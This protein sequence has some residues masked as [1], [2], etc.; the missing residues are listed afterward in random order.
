[1]FAVASIASTPTSLTLPPS[2]L[3]TTAPT[4]QV[5]TRQTAAALAAPLNNLPLGNDAK[6]STPVTLIAN[7]NTSAT[8]YAST[9]DSTT[10]SAASSSFLAQLIGQNDDS[11]N[12]A[13]ASASDSFT[14]APVYDTFVQYS[15]IKF[16]P[17]SAGIN[18]EQAAQPAA[19]SGTS[20]ATA[21]DTVSATILPMS[22][23]Q[24]YSNTQARNQ[25]QLNSDSGPQ[26][27][28]AG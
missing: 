1:M 7:D 3:G 16:K 10:P 2:V 26:V 8:Q 6:P 5:S 20:E 25:S 17:S 18:D 13:L 22:R 23:F 27:S 24:A 4:D 14:P 12:V 21:A 11:A 15:F 9:A 19:P 28:V